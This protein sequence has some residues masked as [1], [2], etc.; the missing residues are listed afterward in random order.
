MTS[1]FPLSD[2]ED[3]RAA[4]PKPDNLSL[5]EPRD[6]EGS[7]GGKLFTFSNSKGTRPF[8][9]FSLGHIAAI[10]GAQPRG[11]SWPPPQP[12]P[13][14]IGVYDGS[15]EGWEGN[16]GELGRAGGDELR[17]PILIDFPAPDL[18]TTDQEPESL[19]VNAEPP[20]SGSNKVIV[21]IFI[22]TVII[23][24]IIIVTVCACRKRSRSLK[25]HRY[26]GPRPGLS[27]GFPGDPHGPH[28]TLPKVFHVLKQKVLK[29][30]Y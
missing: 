17:E 14:H 25:Y 28:R 6:Q 23:I 2:L 8:T 12:F 22:V 16:K 27:H 19:Q 30:P 29:G 5:A 3:T 18:D 11:P 20:P 10:S 4:V 24:V 15:V 21:V 26:E 7:K 13:T 1:E 9:L